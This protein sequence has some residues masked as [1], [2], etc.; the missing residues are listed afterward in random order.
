[1]Q[2][3]RHLDWNW[4]VNIPNGQYRGKSMASL[5]RSFIMAPRIL[6]SLLLVGCPIGQENA[7]GRVYPDSHLHFGYVVEQTNDHGYM[8]I[9]NTPSSSYDPDASYAKL[10]PDAILQW[11]V[12]VPGL[13]GMDGKDMS[14]AGLVTSEGG[15]I[16]AGTTERDRVGSN[17]GTMRV[18]RVDVSGQTVWDY[19]YGGE[20]WFPHAIAECSGTGYVIAGMDSTGYVYANFLL[21]LDTL[22]NE[23]WCKTVNANEHIMAMTDMVALHDD[24]F[25]VIGTGH[26]AGQSGLL[27]GSDVALMKA[28]DDGNIVWWKEYP[29]ENEQHPFAVEL[30]PDGG[31]LI[32]GTSS[33]HGLL[34][35]TD[36]DGN[37]LWSRDDILES[38]RQSPWPDVWDMVVGDD[39]KIAIVGD[40]EKIG[41][42]FGQPVWLQRAFILQLDSDGNLLW[43]RDLDKVWIF[44]MCLTDH[45][46]YMTTGTDGDNLLMVEVDMNGN[47]VN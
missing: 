9:G 6:V 43:E 18:R 7:P 28:D 14:Q 31:F 34:M 5:K 4:A 24:A 21:K 32:A 26:G 15:I 17:Y 25:V 45:N 42:V 46:T 40:D 27:Y 1:M 47:V 33:D 37:L 35:K 12:Q 22:G 38:F 8:V 44:G 36:A 10:G 16:L 19:T 41:Y 30:S 3:N 29:M 11:S 2:C 13:Y 39:G 20:T 23:V